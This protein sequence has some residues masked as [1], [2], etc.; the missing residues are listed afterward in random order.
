MRNISDYW[1][2]RRD[3]NTTSSGYSYFSAV[4]H[5]EDVWQLYIVFGQKNFKLPN[6]QSFSGWKSLNS[7]FHTGPFS[8]SRGGLRPQGIILPYCSS[9]NTHQISTSDL[10]NHLEKNYI[11]FWEKKNLMKLFK[12]VLEQK[13]KTNIL[14]FQKGSSQVLKNQTQPAEGIFICVL[15]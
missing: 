8:L 5:Y 1:Q 3:I 10:R 9:L 2:P 11:L 13:Q 7:V 14:P 6:L 15:R 4:M 12:M